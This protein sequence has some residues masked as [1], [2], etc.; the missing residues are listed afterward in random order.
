MASCN[1]GGQGTHLCDAWFKI[2]GKQ[3]FLLTWEAEGS[4]SSIDTN[5]C[6]LAPVFIYDHYLFV[7]HFIL[8]CNVTNLIKCIV[9]E[10]INQY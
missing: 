6:F 8:V 4:I 7:Y 1:Y 9:C 2:L 10:E 5:D 3:L